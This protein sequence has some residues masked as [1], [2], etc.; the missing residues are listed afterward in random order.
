MNAGKSTALLQVAHNY[1]ERNMRVLVMKPGKDTKGE[2]MLVSRLGIQRKVDVVFSEDDDLVE[3]VSQQPLIYCILVDEAQ[4]CTKK[5]IDQLFRLA[6]V[7]NI[8]VICY[9]LRTDFQME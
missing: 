8:P 3:V 2:D 6:A 7:D 5:Q 1:E 4:F 9:G